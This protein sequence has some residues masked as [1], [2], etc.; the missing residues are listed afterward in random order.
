MK[1]ICGILAAVL[2]VGTLGAAPAIAADDY[3]IKSYDGTAAPGGSGT[4]AGSNTLAS[5]NGLKFEKGVTAAPQCAADEAVYHISGRGTVNADNKFQYAFKPEQDNASEGAIS[6]N[7]YRTSF[8]I[9][10]QKDMKFYVR[11]GFTSTTGVPGYVDATF[12]TGSVS[13]DGIIQ[14]PLNR[15][16]HIT[17]DVKINNTSGWETANYYVDG[18]KKGSFGGQTI[19]V[20]TPLHLSFANFALVMVKDQEYDF[21]FDNYK[22][23]ASDSAF[24]ETAPSI[25]AV[26]AQ[27]GEL[28]AESMT[29]KLA[30]D[31]TASALKAAVTAENATL[32]VYR[33]E[34]A[35]A[36]GSAVQDGDLL[37]LKGANGLYSYYEL[38]LFNVAEPVVSGTAAAGQTV[39]AEAQVSGAA[40][41]E[42]TL[43]FVLYKGITHIETQI[44]SV[45]AGQT[46]EGGKLLASI[47]VPSGEGNYSVKAFLWDSLNGMNSV[48]VN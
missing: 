10:P 18:V 25:A 16:A 19:G 45:A 26:G 32:A 2:M 42:V 5:G 23:M 27:A 14:I 37:C 44:A 4:T 22:T 46:A 31:I 24:A 39:K 9:Y 30:G 28:D 36:D 20:P 13:G 43:I 48:P 41:R 29:I 12:G 40:D 3:L 38:K 21:Y 15:W 33:G 34:T 7:Y 11:A 8:D 17:V 35:V 47:T 1:K 6:R